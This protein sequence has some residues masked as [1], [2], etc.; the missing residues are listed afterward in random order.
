M[1]FTRRNVF[2]FVPCLEKKIGKRGSE[3]SLCEKRPT[4]KTVILLI[5]NLLYIYKL[6][7]SDILFTME[8]ESTSFG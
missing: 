5:A 6:V 4:A 2:V 1:L 3:V 7:M 8:T